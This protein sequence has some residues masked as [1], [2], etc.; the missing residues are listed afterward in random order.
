LVAELGILELGFVDAAG[1]LE[2]GLVHIETLHCDE[3]VV[4][5]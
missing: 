3:I 5:H 4:L 1:E 2:C